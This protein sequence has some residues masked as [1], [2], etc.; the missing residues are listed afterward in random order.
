MLNRISSAQGGKKTSLFSHMLP[1]FLPANTKGNKRSRT[2]TDSYSAGQSVGESAAPAEAP[3]S[4]SLAGDVGMRLSLRLSCLLAEALEGIDLGETTHKKAGTTVP[5]SIHSFSKS[6][7]GSLHCRT[8]SSL[9]SFYHNTRP[10]AD[11]ND[12]CNH[13]AAARKHLCPI[14][15][16]CKET[17]IPWRI[18]L[19]LLITDAELCGSFF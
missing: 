17:K 6:P 16:S 12:W 5:E 9:G 10:P 4:S 18:F 8:F 19:R 3:A 14:C 1:V 7:V 15:V 13:S 11:V 2:R